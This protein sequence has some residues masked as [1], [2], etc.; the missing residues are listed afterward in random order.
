MLSRIHLDLEGTVQHWY[1]ASKI[2][3]C[4]IKNII[5]N[6]DV[7]TDIKSLIPDS[8]VRRRMSRVLKMAVSTA[9]EC[10]HGINNINNIDAIITSTGYGCL[11]DSEKFLR[12]IIDNKEELLNPTP[13]IQ[14]TFNTV[15][16]QIALLSHNHCEN[17]T[18][19]NRSHSFEDALLDSFL[20]LKSGS[21]ERILLGS[22][23]EVTESSDIIL[24]RM[25]TFRKGKKNGEGSVFTELSSQKTD[26]CKA[27]IMNVA[28]VNHVM[29]EKECLAIYSSKNNCRLVMNSYEDYGL[30]P[31]VS[32]M[33]LYH[34]IADIIA[35]EEVII[36]NNYLGMNSSVI[37]IKG[38]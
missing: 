36:C 38:L 32:S 15:G 18:Y 37:V 33:I 31:T 35:D 24:H 25:G 16:G 20:Q 5:S 1:L 4:Y 17:I 27:E 14:S 10:C 21:A 8:T 7:R 13:F 9:I 34:C 28:F 2:M 6:D 23:D 29:S 11:A 12:N 26:E 3:G 19:V 22:F 30:Y